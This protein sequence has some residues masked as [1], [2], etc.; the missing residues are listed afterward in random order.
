M[1]YKQKFNVL[2][3]NLSYNVTVLRIIML[4]KKMKMPISP[5]FSSRER[6]LPDTSRGGK[7][8][9]TAETTSVI[10]L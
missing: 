9:T 10:H 5:R 2:K 1:N 4:I 3:K 6:F 8:V 7:K